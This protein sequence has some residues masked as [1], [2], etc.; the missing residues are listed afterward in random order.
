MKKQICPPCTEKEQ[1]LIRD[2]EHL[3][4]KITGRLWNSF[5][6]LR[7]DDLES[8]AMSGLVLAAIKYDPNKQ[9]KNKTFCHYALHAGFYSAIDEMRVDG[10]I[11]RGRKKGP[12]SRKTDWTTDICTVE[13]FYGREESDQKGDDGFDQVDT[14]DFCHEVVKR[15]KPK[16]KQLLKFF[17]FD[18]L[19]KKQIADLEGVSASMISFRYR[20]V[21][22]KMKRI[23]ERIMR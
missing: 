11:N 4:G 5:H 3:I 6:W 15:L 1:D 19:L 17:L 2:N 8:Y 22:K 21:V 16:E 20:D 10:V 23:A 18:N 7:W 14:R 13:D 12:Q 9:K